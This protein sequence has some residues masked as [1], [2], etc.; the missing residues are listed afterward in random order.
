MLR[1]IGAWL[2][3]N[4]EAIYGSRPW[5]IYGE[6]PTKTVE[7]HLSEERNK[8]LGPEDIRFTSKGD[9]L[10][11]TALGRAEQE[12]TIESLRTGSEHLEGR[13][14]SRVRLLGHDG[15]LEWSQRSDALAIRNPG[16]SLAKH[17]YVFE[18]TLE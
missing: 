11:A 4:G 7:G 9:A 18:V 15:A 5:K 3:T 10:Y 17:A 13:A 12:W 6:G 1:E 14:V 16:P 2:Q 8:Q